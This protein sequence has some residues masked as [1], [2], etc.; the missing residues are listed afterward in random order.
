MRG[1]KKEPRGEPDKEPLK[2]KKEEHVNIQEAQFGKIFC[3]HCKKAFIEKHYHCEI[4]QIICTSEG[5]LAQHN[6]GKAHAEKVKLATDADQKTKPPAEPSADI[7]TSSSQCRSQSNRL[8]FCHAQGCYATFANEI[9][10]KR[11]IRSL[12]GYLIKCTECVAMKQTPAEVLTCE[13]LIKHYD[14]AHNKVMKE[15]DLKFFGDVKNWKQGYVKCKLCDTK[16]GSPGLWFTNEMNMTVIGAHF[17]DKHPHCKQI[18]RQRQITLGCQLCLFKVEGSACYSWLNHLSTHAPDDNRDSAQMNSIGSSSGLVTSPCVFCGEKVVKSGN[19]EQK[20]IETQHQDLAFQ[21]KLC[22]PA[23]R[24]YYTRREQVLDH[25]RLKHFGQD[26]VKDENIKYPGDRNSLLGFAWIKCKNCEFSGVGLGEDLIQ[27][28]VKAH[29]GGGI[30]F[31]NI[32]CRLCHKDD[33][34][35]DVLET[36]EEFKDHMKVK[37][38]ELLKKLPTVM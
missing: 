23:D 4:C 25:L 24:Y 35:V 20:H 26:V 37:H 16:L 17:E 2:G 18:P 34:V 13:E 31:F 5:N 14:E 36:A 38:S 27:H 33:R 19:A 11:H 30:K 9:Q 32:F 28:Q 29:Y 10:L 1:Q 22:V 21:C 3:K 15:Y 7:N 12:H 8:L 6:A